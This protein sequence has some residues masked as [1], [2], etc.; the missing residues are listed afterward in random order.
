VSAPHP[1]PHPDQHPD[2]RSRPYLA[3]PPMPVDRIRIHHLVRVPIW[4]R[5]QVIGWDAAVVLADQTFQDGEPY[6][7]VRL[8]APGAEYDGQEVAYYAY[9]I[10]CGLCDA[11]IGEPCPQ[12][13]PTSPST[14]GEDDPSGT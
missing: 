12:C 7:V 6:Y 3:V 9:S 13:R 14:N 10:Q 1:D 4:V 11:G 5:G 2:S 8:T